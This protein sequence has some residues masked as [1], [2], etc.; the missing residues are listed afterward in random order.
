MKNNKYTKVLRWHD[1]Y[2]TSL[3]LILTRQLDA[4]LIIRSNY[5]CIQ[6]DI[7]LKF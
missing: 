7:L 6:T 5:S 1:T 3:N 4:I 2:E